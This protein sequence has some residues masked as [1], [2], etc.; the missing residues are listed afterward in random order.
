MSRD[1]IISRLSNGIRV[2]TDT[3]PT[4]DSVTLGVW[5][6]VGSRFEKKSES[7]ISHF[8]EHMAFKGT[9]T[10]SALQIAKEIEQVG[11]FINAYTGQDVTAYHARML[12]KDMDIGLNIIADITQHAIMDEKELN[13][14][15]GV[16]IQEINMYKDQPHYMAEVNFD[17][18]A[19]PNQPLGR[20]VAGDP[21]V[22]RQMTPQKM[23]DY[24]HSHYAMDRIVISAVGPIQHDSF[25]K[26]CE[27]LF[28][29]FTLKKT[30]ISE[31]AH[32]Q[33]GFK[34]VKKPHEQ[35]NLIVGFEGE[36]YTSP[37]IWKAKL[38]AAILGGGMTSRLFQEIREK[39]GLVYT[40]HAYASAETDTGIWGIYAGTGE[41]ELQVLMPVLVDEL[42]KA[43]HKITKEEVQQ[44]Q[45]RL[46]AALLMRNEDL[47]E[48]ADTNAIEFLRYGRVRSKA[49]LIKAIRAVT[50]KEIQQYAS[51]I[52]AT[53]PTLSCL[54]PIKHMMSYDDVIKQLRS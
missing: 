49:S 12:K 50:P 54:G 37:D 9:T 4:L 31:P 44:A 46:E 39:R 53:K 15:K 7:G 18:T 13:T 41:K 28:C 5:V 10:R 34:Y 1:V 6:G 35:V 42:K 16:I 36:S 20:E 45:T 29:D 22:I 48:H 2:I 26:K 19:Y 33:G 47:P 38:L 27:R 14:E 43:T 8:L 23:L 3:Q 51:R 24:V 21:E 17:A 32:Y 11:G 30:P 25:V 40:I 52:F